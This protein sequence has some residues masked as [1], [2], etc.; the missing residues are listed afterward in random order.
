VRKPDIVISEDIRSSPNIE[1]NNFIVE[2]ESHEKGVSTIIP[3]D[4][5]S[6]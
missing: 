5:K 3:E 4:L 6:L 1:H 2:V